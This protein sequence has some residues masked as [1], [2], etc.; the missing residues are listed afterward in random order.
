MENET[1]L[2][3]MLIVAF[4]IGLVTVATFCIS[5]FFHDAEI[6]DKSNIDTIEVP[7]VETNIYEFK[8]NMIYY[9]KN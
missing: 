9:G 1:T 4:I 5:D 8:H 3:K 7:V 2:M 6:Y